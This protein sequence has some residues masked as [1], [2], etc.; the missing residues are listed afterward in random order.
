MKHL[1]TFHFVLR[2]KERLNILFKQGNVIKYITL[3]C[4]QE[5][6]IETIQNKRQPVKAKNVFFNN[7]LIRA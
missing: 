7:D 5:Q 1:L 4:I 3:R 6:N 2:S